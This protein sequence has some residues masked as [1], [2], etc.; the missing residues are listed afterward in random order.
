[1]KK[2]FVL[3]VAAIGLLALAGC[4]GPSAEEQEKQKQEIIQIETAN[5]TVDSTTNE[6]SKTSEELDSLLNQL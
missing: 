5:E 2:S 3:T 1:M 6:V 4:G